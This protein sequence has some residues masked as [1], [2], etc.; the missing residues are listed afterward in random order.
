MSSMPGDISNVPTVLDALAKAKEAMASGSLPPERLIQLVGSASKSRNKGRKAPD[1]PEFTFPDSGYT[2]RVRRVGPWT[3][4][5]ISQSVRQLRRPPSIPTINVPDQYDD[6]GNI[7]SYRLELND[8]DPQY[9][10]DVK[11]YETWVQTAAG[12]RLLD[13]IVSSCVV[14]NKDDMDEEEIA[15]HRRALVLAGPGD[16]DDPELAE[17]HRKKIESMPDEEI[18]V[19]CV[20][21]ATSEDMTSLQQFVTSR[22]MPTIQEVD[23]Q[24]QNFRPEVQRSAVVQDQNTVERVLVQSEFPVGDGYPL[25]R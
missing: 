14:I 4:D 3:L 8:A 11:E 5:Q 6:A 17:R 16:D 20:C 2:V 21:M 13:V 1:L 15:S 23:E 22:S 19:R 10:Q 9:K 7:R 18:F 24:V 12:Y 25:V